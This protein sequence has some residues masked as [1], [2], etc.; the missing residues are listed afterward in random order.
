[1]IEVAADVV[2]STET[3]TAAA[4][5]GVAPLHLGFPRNWPAVF[6]ENRELKGFVKVLGGKRCREVFHSSDATSSPTAKPLQSFS[7]AE[8][9][10][11]ASDGWKLVK[12]W[13]VFELLDRPEGS[14]FVAVRHW[15]AASAD[16]VWC[17][18]TP[19]LVGERRGLL[20]ESPQGNKSR[21]SVSGDAQGATMKWAQRLLPSVGTSSTVEGAASAPALPPVPPPAT[22]PSAPPEALVVAPLP[23]A[24]TPPVGLGP[25][26]L[27]Q[28]VRISGLT[29]RPDLNGREGEALSF[30]AE[31]GRYNVSVGT[32]KVALRPS[33]LAIATAS[34]RRMGATEPGRGVGG[35]QAAGRLEKSVGEA[36][37]EALGEKEVQSAGGPAAGEPQ[38]VRLVEVRQ[39]GDAPKMLSWQQSR[40]LDGGGISS[41][42]GVDVTAVT[43]T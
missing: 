25:A 30:V 2:G 19:G 29:A 34:D 37:G 36:L 22:V 43:V 12:G 15:W 5:T 18:P 28:T 41:R 21:E 9:L 26:L 31:T 42:C 38:E 23:S 35:Q 33:N 8:D 10:V 32:E 7:N 16:G 1:M 17:D 40:D 11:L 13:Q 6:K 39:E 24:A 27:G 20:I 3:I 14:A 4:R